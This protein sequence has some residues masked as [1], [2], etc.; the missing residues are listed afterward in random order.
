MATKAEGSQGQIIWCNEVTEGTT[1]G[2]PTCYKAP[3]S[4]ET[5]GLS[6]TLIR[7]NNIRSDKNSEFLGYGVKRVAGD[8]TAD[9]VYRAY[10]NWMASLLYGTWSG[11]GTGTYLSN[12]TTK[13]FMTIEKGLTDISKYLV[14]TGMV[15]TGMSFS[16]TPDQLVTTTYSFM[17]HD[18][19]SA[20][21]SIDASPADV[22]GLGASAMDFLG[23]SLTEGGSPIAVVTDMSLNITNNAADEGF[24]LGS[25]TRCN[26]FTGRIIVTGSITIYV[27]NMTLY[28]KFLNGT[29]SELVLTLA[30][31]EGAQYAFD[32]PA[33]KYS[34]ETPKIAGEGPVKMNMPFEAYYSSSD[35][36]TIKVTRTDAT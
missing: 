26:V 28:N 17:G 32:I 5:L 7:S 29:A 14:Y 25:A 9:L 8:V 13:S 27:E 35:G 34:G 19:S 12:G 6:K 30:D 31:A 11:A 18:E 1:P 4:S 23:A 33:I 36:Y 22:T 3:I 15:C 2:S 21:S 10:D 20:T 24:T 16:V